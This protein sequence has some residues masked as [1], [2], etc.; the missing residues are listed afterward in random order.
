MDSFNLANRVMIT[1]PSPNVDSHF[2]PYTSVEEA[3]SVI[4]PALRAKSKVVGIIVGEEVIDYYWRYGITDGDLVRKSGGGGGDPIEDY[5][6]A[7]YADT[8]IEF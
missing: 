3:N 2:G 6:Y 4:I 5:D 1:N 8:I 7:A